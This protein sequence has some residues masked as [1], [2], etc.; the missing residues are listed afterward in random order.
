MLVSVTLWVGY[1]SCRCRRCCVTWFQLFVK[2]ALTGTQ[3]LCVCLHV[4]CTGWLPRES[5]SCRGCDPTP[6]SDGQGLHLTSSSSDPCY[7]V[8]DILMCQKHHWL[9]MLMLLTASLYHHHYF[10]FTGSDGRNIKNTKQADMPTFP[11]I[12]PL[13]GPL[14]HAGFIKS[15]FSRNHRKQHISCHQIDF[16]AQHAL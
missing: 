2:S 5:R 9:V 8:L 11:E 7:S 4:Q 16:Q 12:L 14:S 15:R 6:S 10:R 1:W 13:S 3:Q